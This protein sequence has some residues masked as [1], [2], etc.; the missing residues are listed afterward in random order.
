LQKQSGK[1]SNGTAR[2]DDIIHNRDME[3][4]DRQF[5]AK[6]IFQVSF[7]K[8]GIELM[9]YGGGM[10]A[11]KRDAAYRHPSQ[12]ASG[13]R[14]GRSGYS[15][16]ASGDGVQGTFTTMSI[17]AGRGASRLQN[18][19]QQQAGQGCASVLWPENFSCESARSAAGHNHPPPPAR[20][21]AVIFQAAAA[22]RL[23]AGKPHCGHPGYGLPASA[24]RRS[25][26]PVTQ[27]KRHS[28]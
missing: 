27:R 6:G 4:F 5:K 3:T 20:S 15:R 8:P 14:A 28:A 12:R 16:A 2:G 26:P 11:F 13:G 10:D 19:Q 25:R 22:N 9:L 24:C 18:R 23:V 1:F 17:S 7:A 21:T